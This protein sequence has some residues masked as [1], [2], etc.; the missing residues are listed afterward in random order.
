MTKSFQ[1]LLYRTLGF[2]KFFHAFFDNKVHKIDEKKSKKNFK[3]FL[4]TPY[5]TY[6]ENVYR[7]YI[8]S[9]A[10]VE[11]NQDSLIDCS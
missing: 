2:S 6:R 8:D 9:R 11:V 7:W 3:K 5:R 4:R 1:T 10:T